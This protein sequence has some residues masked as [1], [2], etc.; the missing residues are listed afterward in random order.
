[1]GVEKLLVELRLVAN[2]ECRAGSLE[3]CR[4]VEELEELRRALRKCNGGS[5]G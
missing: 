3:A 4:L 5:Q 2:Q 1:M